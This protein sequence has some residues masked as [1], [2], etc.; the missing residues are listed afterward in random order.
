MSTKKIIVNNKELIQSFVINNVDIKVIDL[1]LGYSVDVACMKKQDNIL[2]STTMFNI[3]GDEYKA[4][5]NN[6]TY[7][8]D[9]ILNK[10]GL[11]RKE[12]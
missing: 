10:L 6:D 2:V 11:T 12:S 7:L 9:I 4:W 5:G 8:E 1:N 3:S